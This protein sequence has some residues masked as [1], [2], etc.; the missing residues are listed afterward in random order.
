M[1]HQIKEINSAIKPIRKRDRLSNTRD[2]K[3]KVKAPLAKNKPMH[4]PTLAGL[5]CSL[6]VLLMFLNAEISKKIPTI[7]DRVSNTT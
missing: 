3:N 1:K 5:L 4:I 6:K 7:A 2:G